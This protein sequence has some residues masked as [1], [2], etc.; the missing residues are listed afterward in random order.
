MNKKRC[1]LWVLIAL[2]VAGCASSGGGGG[3][4]EETDFTH[5]LG[6]VSYAVLNQGL[7]RILPRY[8]YAVRRREE[9]FSNFYIE[10]DWKVREPFADEQAEGYT[11]AR[12][13]L[14]IQGRRSDGPVFRTSVQVEN[15]VRSA[16]THD[17][18][19]HRALH[20]PACPHI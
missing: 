1:S 19:V 6:R 16:S 9:Q 11:A 2:A 13:R 14:V 10:T 20:G 8:Q 7:D 4:G 12:T 15:H 5:S 3:S 18:D 17:L